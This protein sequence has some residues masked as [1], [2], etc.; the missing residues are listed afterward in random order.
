MAF[1]LTR[2][3]VHLLIYCVIRQNLRNEIN[4][5]NNNTNELN[6]LTFAIYNYLL[7][8]IPIVVQQEYSVGCQ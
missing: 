4:L 5:G 1:F 6:K 3:I 8:I 2:K 7:A